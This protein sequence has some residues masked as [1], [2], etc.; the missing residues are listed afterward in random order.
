MIKRILAVSA[1][2]SVGLLGLTALPAGAA[3]GPSINLK[4]NASGALKFSSKTLHATASKSTKCNANHNTFILTNK[5]GSSEE[6]D[7]GSNPF[8]TSAPGQVNFICQGIGTGT[9]T[10]EGSSTASLTVTVTL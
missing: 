3:T 10:V 9:Y 1:V 7:F 2:G 8:F 5:T 6:I 4:M